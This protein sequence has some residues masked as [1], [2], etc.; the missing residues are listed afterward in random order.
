M[1]P[2]RAKLLAVTMMAA[3]M[4]VLAVFVEVHWALPVGVGSLLAVI[5]AYIVSR[6]SVAPV[7][8]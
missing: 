7:A 1:I 4:T 5:T 2:L 6:P 3:S 8:Q